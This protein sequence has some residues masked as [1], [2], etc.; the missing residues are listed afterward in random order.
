[1]EHV[2]TTILFSMAKHVFAVLLSVKKVKNVLD[3][4]ARTLLV[5]IRPPV[6][7]V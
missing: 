3:T 2:P 7:K 6:M 5:N 4:M 1:M